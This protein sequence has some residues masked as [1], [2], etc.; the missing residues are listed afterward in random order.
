MVIIIVIKKL[1][2]E[3]VED[4]APSMIALQARSNPINQSKASFIN[5]ASVYVHCYQKCIQVINQASLNCTE[6]MSPTLRKKRE[7]SLTY[8]TAEPL[9]V[10]IYIHVIK[11]R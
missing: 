5:I 8:G 4:L 6:L 11:H 9:I 1:K 7:H 10:Y 2:M 3:T